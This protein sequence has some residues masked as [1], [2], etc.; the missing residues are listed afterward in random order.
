MTTRDH[1]AAR[2]IMA[3]YDASD[4]PQEWAELNL[5]FHLCLYRACNRPR[6]LKMIEEIVR[7]IGIHLRAQQSY[8]AGQKSPQSE[9]REILKSCIARDVER[10]TSLLESHIE[11]TQ[12]ALKSD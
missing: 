8:K 11:H 2:E 6:L 5:E 7:S 1:K 3:R 9:H 10:A 4:S 12:R